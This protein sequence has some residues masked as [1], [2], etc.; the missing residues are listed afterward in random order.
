MPCAEI[1][2]FKSC[3]WPVSRT[4]RDDAWKFSVRPC[5][6]ALGLMQWWDY[7]PPVAAPSPQKETPGKALLADQENKKGALV[8]R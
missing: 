6:S 4:T 2:R 8:I 5:G 3:R 1:C 7:R